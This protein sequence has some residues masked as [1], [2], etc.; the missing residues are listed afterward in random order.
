MTPFLI[1]IFV[2]GERAYCSDG[3]RLFY[4]AE[5]F[6]KIFRASPKK[7]VVRPK[8]E[9]FYAKIRLWETN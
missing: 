8:S 6:K 7:L 4:F 1:K 9:F 5:N 2:F 3:S